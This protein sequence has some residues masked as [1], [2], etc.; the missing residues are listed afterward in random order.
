MKAKIELTIDAIVVCPKCEC[1][2]DVTSCL[3]GA[4]IRNI[5]AC[6]SAEIENAKSH[7]CET[8]GCVIEIAG[9]DEVIM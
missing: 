4:T 7:T 2:D 9:A 1:E 8:C 5:Q 6:E 3:D